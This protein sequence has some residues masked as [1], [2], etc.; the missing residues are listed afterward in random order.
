M[1][2][3]AVIFDM[4]GVLLDTERL[5]Y[6]YWLQAAKE[7]GYPL[8]PQHALDLRSLAGKFA[9]EYIRDHISPDIDYDKLRQR[10][11]ELMSADLEANGIPAKPGAAELLTMLRQKRLKTAVAT[12][13]DEPRTRKYLAEVGILDLFDH[14]CCAT[15]VENGKPMPDVYLF[16]CT[17]LKERPE[18]CIAVEDS[19]NGV[20]SA[21]RAGCRVAMIPDLSQPDEATAALLTYKAESLTA[22]G[23]ILEAL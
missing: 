9:A 18:D 5:L 23:N 2:I 13:T 22:L 1:P 4:D 6:K 14:I 17:Q 20:L 11:R 19:P 12:A 8:K 16:A 7:L 10:R 21:H 15:M 3:H